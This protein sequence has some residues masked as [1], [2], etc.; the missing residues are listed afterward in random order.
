MRVDRLPSLDAARVEWEQDPGL[1]PHVFA[2][3]EWLDAWWRHHGAGKELLLHVARSEQGAPVS[4]LPLYAWR[5]RRV[6]VLRFIGHGPADELGPIAAAGHAEAAVHALRLVLRRL[7]W[8]VFL[9]ELLPRDR[10]WSTRLCAGV[11][12]RDASPVLRVPRGGWEEFLASRS[13]NFREQLR[14]RR[15]ALERAGR[16]RFRLADAR[17]LDADLDAL[18]ALHLARW[19]RSRT[20]FRDSAFHRDFARRALERGWLRLWMLELD[21]R[22]IAAWHGFVVGTIASYYQ[23]G[24]EPACERFSVG[25]LLLAHSLRAAIEEGVTEYRFGRGAEPYKYRFAD[26]DRGLESIVLWRGAL[27]GA[28]VAG[29]RVARSVVRG[30]RRTRE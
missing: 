20:S 29:A 6:R 25:F 14:R 5:P 27:G 10:S 13:G 17:S 15:R 19:G 11:W 22:P 30:L 2:T 1:Q 16:V 26:L 9:G 23:A 24:R 8:D 4:I 3:W 28:A 18:F 12:S 7:R 21:G